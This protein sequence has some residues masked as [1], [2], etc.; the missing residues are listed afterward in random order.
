MAEAS[1]AEDLT[2]TSS[3]T[4]LSRLLDNLPDGI[5]TISTELEIKYVNPA[6][7][8]IVG[9][10]PDEL[11]GSPITNYLGDLHILEVCMTE[12]AACGH[13]NDQETIFKRKD[14]SVVHISKNVQAI[15]DDSGEC[16]EI[17]VSIRDLSELHHLNKELETYTHRLEET[18]NELRDTQEQLVE[19]EK[20]ASLGSLVAGVAHEINTPLGI[21][22][23]SASS[24]HEEIDALHRQFDKNEMKRS[25]LESFFEQSDHA[26]KI[27]QQNLKRATELV[28][29]FKQV[30]VDQS[31]E[32]EREINLHNYCNEALVSLA[33]KIKT[34]GITV[35]NRIPK[36]INIRIN[37]GAVYQILSNL[38]L[39]SLTH[40]YDP[41]QSGNVNIEADLDGENLMLAYNDDG[42]GIPDDL[43]KRIFDPFF[44]TQR[45]KGGTGLGLSIVY[46]TVSGKLQGSIK[47]DTQ[48][49]KGTEFRMSFPVK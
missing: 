3:S 24:M 32:E 22:V 40:A 16:R 28:R 12:V 46:N 9:Y 30:A 27:L 18:V 14:G 47:V 49:G 7:C 36:D 6:F 8:K 45:G 17:L 35:T 11:I 15:C 26:C 20:L 41:G 2:G 33:P 44:T 13:C 4:S 21:S 10:T 1:T 38:I 34:S 42:K 25:D 5:F 43:V 19:A 39:N 37:P 29:N 48:T 31:I 23:T